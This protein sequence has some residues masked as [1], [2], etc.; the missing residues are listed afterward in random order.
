MKFFVNFLNT[1]NCLLFH[2]LLDFYN[3]IRS[4]RRIHK[5]YRVYAVMKGSVM[6]VFYDAY[7]LFLLRAVINCLSD[8]LLKSHHLHGRLVHNN[9]RFFSRELTGKGAAFL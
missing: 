5:K 8:G 7:D 3:Y 6:K 4:A 1:L 9:F 2:S